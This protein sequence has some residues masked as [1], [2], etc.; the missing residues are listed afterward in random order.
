MLNRLLI[1][2]AFLFFP[3]FWGVGVGRGMGLDFA[4]VLGSPF[5]L[6]VQSQPLRRLGSSLRTAQLKAPRGLTLCSLCP[7]R[8]AIALAVLEVC[9]TNWSHTQRS[10]SLIPEV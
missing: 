8:A 7:L 1:L 3:F 5:F 10:A 2:R 9:R 6:K 4:L